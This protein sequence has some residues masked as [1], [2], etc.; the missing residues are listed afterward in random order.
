MSIPSSPWPVA[1]QAAAQATPLTADERLV[2]DTLRVMT[3]PAVER[4]DDVAR[5]VVADPSFP[6]LRGI[7]ETIRDGK[8][9]RV[10]DYNAAASRSPP[11]ATSPLRRTA[12][13]S[14]TS[15]APRTPPQPS[16]AC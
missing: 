6:A 4:L 13:A 9:P 3:S 1:A 15:P 11:R 5:R 16:R 14:P 10:A 12:S 8:T 2:R 7:L